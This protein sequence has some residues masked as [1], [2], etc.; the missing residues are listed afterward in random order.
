MIDG[1]EFALGRQFVQIN[2]N[3]KACLEWYDVKEEKEGLNVF[4]DDFKDSIFDIYLL[5]RS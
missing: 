3:D 1:K 2:L 5:F 4:D